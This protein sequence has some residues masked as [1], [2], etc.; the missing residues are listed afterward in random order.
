MATKTYL[1]IADRVL[2]QAAYSIVF[3]ALPGV[4]SVAATLAGGRAISPSRGEVGGRLL[5][6]LGSPIGTVNVVYCR[7]LGPDGG[8][9][10]ECAP[11]VRF[12]NRPDSFEGYRVAY[13]KRRPTR[14]YVMR[15]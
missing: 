9:L 2:G 6:A 10:V 13:E 8:F 5:A 7:E 3:S 4:A 15:A 1:A 11:G 12:S 14:P